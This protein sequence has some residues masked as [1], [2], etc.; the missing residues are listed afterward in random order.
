MRAFF[1]RPVL[2]VARDLLGAR[3]TVR[4]VAGAVTV[5]LTEVEAYDG[6]TDPGSHAYR[7][8]TARN[9]TMFGAGGHLY[10]YRHLGLHHCANIV[11]G[12]EG[13]ASGILLR[14]AEVT[15]GVELARERRVAAG[16]VRADRDLARGPA[17]LTV[18]LGIDASDDGA[19]VTALEGRITLEPRPGPPFSPAASP[20]LATEPAEPATASGRGPGD[21]RT[22]PRVGV[23]GD[24]GRADLFPW[25]FWLAGEPTVSDY[26]A[27]A[28]RRRRAAD[29][30]AADASTTA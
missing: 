17:R 3:L 22:G 21:I 23:S 30:M 27:A 26:R 29:G 28:L 2:D 13:K 8:R 6:E 1:D 9:A 4:S 14:A 24:G 5:R 18:A 10:V 16:V 12:P 15:D 19:D 7:G 20:V 25:R 11:C